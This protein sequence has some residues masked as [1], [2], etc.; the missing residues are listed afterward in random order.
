M[1]IAPSLAAC[2]FY[3]G[4]SLTI[5]PNVPNA[6][7]F[8]NLFDLYRIKKITVEIFTSFTDNLAVS[9]GVIS[10]PVVHIANDYNSTGSY[11][12][13][14]ILQ[15]PQMHTYQLG[16]KPIKWSFYPHVRA[17]VLT[18]ITI[19]TSSSAMQEIS[20]WLDT[21][22]SNILHLG[23]MIYMNTMGYTSST[24][25]GTATMLIHYDFEFKNVK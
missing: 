8:T 24:N 3:I 22:S 15:Y 11:A 13:S 5:A 20:P 18:D 1:R 6:S 2:D 4:G 7:E 19:P 23:C 16:A 17:D 14:D 21:S 9:P 12:L 10:M 25:I